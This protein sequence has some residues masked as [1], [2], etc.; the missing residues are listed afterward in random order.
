MSLTVHFVHLKVNRSR[1]LYRYPLQIM[2]VLEQ[3]VINDM[4]NH[5]FCHWLGC[6][7]I[8][9]KRRNSTGQPIELR[10][11]TEIYRHHHF[12]TPTDAVKV[13]AASP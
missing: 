2:L 12:D 4:D 11:Y 13:T 5:M 1:Y 10:L 7:W 8:S 3:L 6:G 9:A